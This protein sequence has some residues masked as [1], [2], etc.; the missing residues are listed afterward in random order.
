MSK[1]GAAAAAAAAAALGGLGRRRRR[2]QR[3]IRPI[4]LKS[5]HWGRRAAAPTATNWRRCSP[6]PPRQSCWSCRP[7][8]LHWACAPPPCGWWRPRP[9]RQRQRRRRRPRPVRRRPTGVCRRPAAGTGGRPGSAPRTGPPYGTADSSGWT[10]GDGPRAGRGQV[11]VTATM[12]ECVDM[13]DLMPTSS[14]QKT[15]W[16]AGQ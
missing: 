12:V 8:W 14:Q 15:L 6:R 7:C 10:P 11:T 13:R 9:R 3:P 4:T 5:Q 16:R 1:L 2:Q